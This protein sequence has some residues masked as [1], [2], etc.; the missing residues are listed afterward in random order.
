VGR[1][2]SRARR[3]RTWLILLAAVVGAV[4]LVVLFWPDLYLR[5]DHPLNHES[6]IAAAA[7][8]E[9]VDPYLVAAIIN[10]ESGFR[11]GVVSSAG[12]VG[13]MQVKPSTA[14]AVARSIGLPGT[15][16]EAALSDPETN[17]RVGT[18]YL[19][20]LVTRYDGSVD[21]ALSAYNAGL[22]NAD[23]WAALWKPSESTLSATIDFPETAHYVGEVLA[24]VAVYRRLYPGAFAA[25]RK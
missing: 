22:T 3:R 2:R 1:D 7:A 6:A 8:S 14:K 23:E 19:A 18:A 10:V 12:A 9:D 5:V 17:I 16:D 24:Q 21:L 11:E 13:L 20:E 25:A 15:M 4:A